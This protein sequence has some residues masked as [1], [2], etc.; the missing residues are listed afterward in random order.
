M[1]SV[2]DPSNSTSLE[3]SWLRQVEAAKLR[4]HNAVEQ[5]KA[6]AAQSAGNA[7]GFDLVQA[8]R[9]EAAARADYMRV[10]QAFTD[11]VIHKRGPGRAEATIESSEP[12]IHSGGST[13]D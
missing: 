9:R 13:G 4:Y 5:V 6:V 12:R 8:H 3:E 2:L 1:N 11:L 10:L 7:C